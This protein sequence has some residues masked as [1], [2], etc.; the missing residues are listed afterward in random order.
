MLDFLK[1]KSRFCISGAVVLSL[2][3]TIPS[4]SM[5][6]VLAYN[7]EKTS[8]KTTE[9]SKSESVN[10]TNTVLAAKKY[11]MFSV[12]PD[13]VIKEQSEFLKNLTVGGVMR[14]ITYYRNM[15]QSY[16][17]MVGSEKGLTF[18]DYAGSPGAVAQGAYPTVELALSSRIKSVADFNVG[19]SFAHLFTGQTDG[20][21]GKGISA[22]QNLRFSGNVYTKYAKIGVSAGTVMWVKMSKFT[23]GQAEYRDDY[24]DRYPWDWYRNS[25]LRYDEYYGMGSNVGG[26]SLLRTAFQGVTTNIDF[27][28]SGINL[29]MLFGRT[30]TSAFQGNN[31]AGYPS[32]TVGVRLE[33]SLFKKWFNG[34]FGG[35]YYNRYATELNDY[36]HHYDGN[37]VVSTDMVAKI[38]KIRVSY[39]VAYG[40]VNNPVTNGESER[41]WGAGQ[42]GTAIFGKVELDKKTTT[43]PLSFEA[44]RIDYNFA[45][46]DNSVLNSNASVQTGGYQKPQA[47]EPYGDYDSYLLKNVA[48]EVG[49]YANNRWGWALKAEKKLGRFVL[50]AG[51]GVSQ[52]LENLS[53]TLTI[54]H[55]VA[56]FSRS[57][58]RPWYQQGGPYNRIKSVYRRTYETLTI[59]DA[60]NGESTDYR[61]TFASVDLMGKY[62]CKIFDREFVIMDFFNYTSV[63][64]FFN[65]IPTFGSTPFVYTYY[66]DITAAYHLAKKI[67]LI[68]NVGYEK[69]KGNNRV[70]MFDPTAISAAG[71][72]TDRTKGITLD[73]R[74]YVFG[75]GVSYDFA[76]NA[77]IH[78]RN[79]WLYQNDDT[80]FMEKLF[81]SSRDQQSFPLDKYRGTETTVEMKLFF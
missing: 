47:G 69:M 13:T 35:N 30:N 16:S 23:M 49:Q 38:N 68:G 64:D 54:Q 60:V 27:Y 56:A 61:K 72:T 79:K 10:T 19:Y 12:T 43:F 9:S 81:H 75:L 44:Y 15:N 7:G 46:L 63:Q 14:F 39:E 59:N 11:P 58:F 50:Q 33:K 42:G 4:E 36:T 77:S 21:G 40:K 31:A 52:E 2:M 48:Q 45:S 17:D 76:K 6:Q 24:F 78:L 74:G 8:E 71:V 28:R 37:Y 70:D 65:P 3:L 73:Q 26:Q 80:L 53:N 34:T 1:H 25:F 66:N 57:R 67:T 62:K 41:I 20:D 22:T 5:A 29:M 55:R 18:A 51:W 32:R